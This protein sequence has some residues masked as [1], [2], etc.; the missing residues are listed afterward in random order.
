MSA[1]ASRPRLGALVMRLWPKGAG[2]TFG[3]NGVSRIHVVTLID[4]VSTSKHVHNG[5]TCGAADYEAGDVV[6]RG[7]KRRRV[8]GG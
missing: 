5:A 3:D 2:E 4:N 1:S 7:R 6:A 8:R